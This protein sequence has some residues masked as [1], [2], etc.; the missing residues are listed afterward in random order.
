MILPESKYYAA[1]VIVP[2]AATIGAPEHDAESARTIHYPTLGGA[3]FHRPR[4]RGG[5]LTQDSAGIE[6][7][8][9]DAKMRRNRRIPLWPVSCRYL[10]VYQMLG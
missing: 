9:T 5:A 1:Q 2:S 10:R 6:T 8:Y 4:K 7:F 3:W